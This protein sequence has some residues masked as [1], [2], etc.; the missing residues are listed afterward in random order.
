MIELAEDLVGLKTKQFKKKII[1]QFARN[2]PEREQQSKDKTLKYSKSME[3][4]DVAQLIHNKARQKAEEEDSW[5][6]RTEVHHRSSNVR[7]Q[8]R[9][10]ELEYELS[11]YHRKFERLET[12]KNA[13]TMSQLYNRL[14]QQEGMFQQ[15]LAFKLR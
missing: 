9:I 2:A 1:E 14:G 11:E 15:K 7:L 4:F 3:N 13:S 10:E 12:V 5:Q 6:D 8:K